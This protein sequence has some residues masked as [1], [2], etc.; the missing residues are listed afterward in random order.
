[1]F[2]LEALIIDKWTKNKKV[3]YLES[4]MV[5]TG[6]PSIFIFLEMVGTKVWSSDCFALLRNGSERNCVVFFIFRGIYHIFT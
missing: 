5:R 4:E 3:E 1:M 2:S 6:N